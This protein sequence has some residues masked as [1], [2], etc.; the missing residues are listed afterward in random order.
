MLHFCNCKKELIAE[1]YPQ[2]I[3][4]AYNMEVR[5]HLQ[6]LQV[7]CRTND[8]KYK[9]TH[10]ESVKVVRRLRKYHKPINTH[11]RK[12]AW[13]VAHGLYPLYKVAVRLKYYRRF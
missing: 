8:K 11:H 7:L 10:K 5:T 3:E 13:I 2:Y 1:R 4:Q 6:F 12:L 9:D